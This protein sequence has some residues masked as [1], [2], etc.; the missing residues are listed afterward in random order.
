ME[1]LEF[2]RSFRLLI[3]AILS[4]SL[5]GMNVI[6]I[7][8]SP[9]SLTVTITILIAINI[10]AIP[11]ILGLNYLLYITYMSTKNNKIHYE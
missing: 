1:K 5:M 9:K 7:L 11:G 8:F 6:I 3:A 2:N 10:L 4:M